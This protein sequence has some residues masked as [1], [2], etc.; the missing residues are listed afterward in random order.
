[1]WQ[2]GLG[3]VGRG[4]VWLDSVGYGR[5]GVARQGVAGFVL[6]R[7]GKLRFGMAG[8]VSHGRSRLGQVRYV[9]DWKGSAGTVS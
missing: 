9:M 3:L 7:R 5:R 8:K 1:M 6:V 2:A 4:S